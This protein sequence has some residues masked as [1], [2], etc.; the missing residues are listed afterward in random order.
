MSESI[1]YEFGH[2]DL[3]IFTNKHVLD[4]EHTIP[5][6]GHDVAPKVN[7]TFKNY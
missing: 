3:L 2:G 4:L 1:N 5:K 7:F 6:A